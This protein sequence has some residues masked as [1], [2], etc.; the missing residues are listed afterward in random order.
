MAYQ[1]AQLKT[2]FTR[3]ARTASSNSNP[4][5]CP[6]GTAAVKVRI[7][8]SAVTDTP[9]VVFKVQ[10]EVPGGTWEDLLTSAAVTATGDRVLQVGRGLTASANLVAVAPIPPRIRIVATHG[11]ADSITYLATVEFFG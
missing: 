11:D 1:P 2:A 10:G 8:T 9:S 6:W 4:I 5:P 3:V 7:N